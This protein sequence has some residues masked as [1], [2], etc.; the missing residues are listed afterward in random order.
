MDDK[1]GSDDVFPLT[2]ADLKRFSYPRPSNHCPTCSCQH[3][4][5]TNALLLNR[6]KKKT[7]EEIFE[8]QS[9]KKKTP[10]LTDSFFD[11]KTSTSVPDEAGERKLLAI[12]FNDNQCQNVE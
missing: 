6:E 10:L 5:V 11:I 7:S 8:E 3:Y 4:V 12:Q 2:H 1:H 9:A